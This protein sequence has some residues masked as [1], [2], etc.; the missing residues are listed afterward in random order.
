MRLTLRLTPFLIGCLGSV[1]ANTPMP[2]SLVP[3]SRANLDGAVCLDGSVP[4]YYFAPANTTAD[5]SARSKWVLY[6]KGG[7]WCYDEQSCASRAKTDLGSSDHMPATFDFGGIMDDDPAM[8]PEFAAYNR[9]VMYYCDGASFSGDNAQ[10]YVY[11]K[12]NQTLYFRGKRVLGALLDTLVK[13]H[14][15]GSASQVLLSGGSAGGLSTYLHADRVHDYLKEH[16]PQLTRFKSAPISG[17]FLLHANA[18]GAAVYPSNMQYVFKMQNASS[19]VHPACIASLTA[20]EQW[21][22]M[23]ANYSYAY[24]SAVVFPL[25]SAIDAWQMGNI[26][27]GDKACAKHDFQVC[28]AT[29][30]ADLNDYAHDLVADLKNA[31]SSLFPDGKFGAPGNGGFVESCLE[32]CGAQTSANFMRYAIGGTT[33][34]QALSAWWNDHH[35]A[36]SAKH[37]SLPCDLALATPHQCNPTCDGDDGRY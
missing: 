26:W 6:F 21:K 32:H 3:E 13:K 25:Q 24:T 9:V 1:I 34:Q 29:E 30:V 28:N 7:G 10:P 12:T 31:K 8:N 16:A 36:P 37:W 35:G 20:D 17:F 11:A 4:G 5:A 22:C 19:G 27:Q 15:L 14:G 33:M 23:F 18:A 2:L